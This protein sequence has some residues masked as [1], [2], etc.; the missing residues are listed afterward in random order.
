MK[1]TSLG[2]DR[3]LGSGRRHPQGLSGAMA[4]QN[5]GVP[6]PSDVTTGVESTKLSEIS[7]KEQDGSTGPVRGYLRKLVVLG[8]N[9]SEMSGSH[10]CFSKK[11]KKLVVYFH[12]S[13]VPA[14]ESCIPGRQ[15]VDHL[16]TQGSAKAVVFRGGP[17]SVSSPTRTSLQ[18]AGQ[19]SSPPP[20]ESC[21]LWFC[22][23]G[24][25]G[26]SQRSEVRLGSVQLPSPKGPYLPSGV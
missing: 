21:A 15:P 13:L 12:L 16:F 25:V 1:V 22:H 19:V 17:P 10:F 5:W 8:E 14:L 26:K 20:T 9:Q 23:P 6:D 2:R 24:K 18:G 7:G 3:S 4:G 11:K